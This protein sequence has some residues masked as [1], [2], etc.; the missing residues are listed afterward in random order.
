MSFLDSLAAQ[1][2]DPSILEALR[3][4]ALAPPALPLDQ[5]SRYA[6]NVTRAL[7]PP[8][9]TGPSLDAAQSA[10]ARATTGYR[11]GISPDYYGVGPSLI[12]SPPAPIDPSQHPAVLKRKGMG[13]KGIVPAV[14]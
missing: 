1:L 13:P 11:P 2:N 4:R 8:V 12:E 9:V 7:A 6:A 10:I 14:P 3:S 5:Q